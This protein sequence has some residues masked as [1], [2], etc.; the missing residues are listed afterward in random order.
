M[1]NKANIQ[2]NKLMHL[3]DAMVMY[4]VYNAESSELVNMVH[5]MHINTTSNEKVFVGDF[6]SAFTWYVNQKE[7]LHYAIN[8]LLNLRT[9]REKYVKMYEE[10]IMQLCIYAK[11]IRILAKG[12]LPISLITS[13]RL[14]NIL[15]EVKT[16]VQKTNPDYN[17]VI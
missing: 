16:A 5:I 9:L 4:G 13:L 7:V 12:Y 8:T 15:D 11:A 14:Q 6:S 2:W 3:E 17:I 10:F 1:E